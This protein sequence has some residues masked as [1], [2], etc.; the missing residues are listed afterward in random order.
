MVDGSFG[1][2]DGYGRVEVSA[3]AGGVGAVVTAA[4]ALVS[5]LIDA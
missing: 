5:Y 4:R 1:D 2:G 3:L